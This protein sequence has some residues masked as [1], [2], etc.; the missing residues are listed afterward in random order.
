MFDVFVYHL[1]RMSDSLFLH[2]VDIIIKSFLGKLHQQHQ[3]ITYQN[4]D[5]P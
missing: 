3:H 1:I 5:T 4:W 2:P